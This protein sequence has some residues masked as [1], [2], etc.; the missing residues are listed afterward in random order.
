MERVAGTL[1]R[2]AYDELAA[3]DSSRFSLAAALYVAAAV[4]SLL[5]VAAAVPFDWSPLA[6]ASVIFLGAIGWFSSKQILKL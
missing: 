5:V 4:S 1:S 2:A 3:L 6:E